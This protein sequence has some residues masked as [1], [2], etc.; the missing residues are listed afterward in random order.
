VSKNK[1]GGNERGGLSEE[2][3]VLGKWLLK[4]VRNLHNGGGGKRRGIEGKGCRQDRIG[5]RLRP[6]QLAKCRISRE[7]VGAFGS[8]YQAQVRR[9]IE[10]KTPGEID[11]REQWKKSS[12]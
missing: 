2:K 12:R 7:N 10:H 9:A 1:P 5:S 4:K 11:A 6:S 3:I 8:S